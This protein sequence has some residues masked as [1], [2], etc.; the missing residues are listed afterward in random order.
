M[1]LREQVRICKDLLGLVAAFA[2]LTLDVAPDLVAG[3]LGGFQQGTG[4][5]GD[6][7]KVADERE[8]VR[9]FGEE[10][11]KA[12][13]VAELAVRAGKELGQ[14]T[15]ELLRLEVVEVDLGGAGHFAASWIAS[16]WL[17][18]SSS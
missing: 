9:V 18:R 13:V 17:W 1:R 12:R 5:P 6:G 16:G 11:L 8:I 4:R 7:L 3:I 14:E 10:L 2:Q 15:L